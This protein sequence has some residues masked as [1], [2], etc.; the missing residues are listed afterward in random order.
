MKTK[1]LEKSFNFAMPR[2]H[3]LDGRVAGISGRGSSALGARLSGSASGGR[4]AIALRSG[5]QDRLL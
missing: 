4:R 2:E 1:T 3:G 5:P